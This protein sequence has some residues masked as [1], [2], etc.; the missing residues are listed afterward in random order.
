[1]RLAAALALLVLFSSGARA[2]T[3]NLEAAKSH[4]AAAKAYYDEARYDEALREFREAYRLSKKPALL[5]NIALCDEKQKRYEAAAAS[6][7]LYL[8]LDPKAEDRV[9]IERKIADLDVLVQ[10]PPSPPPEAAQISVVPA[11]PARTERARPA[12]RETGSR[13]RVA[14]W[15]VGGL[16]LALGAA[17][18]G[19]G[20]AA[21][22]DYQ[23]LV[24]TCG[25]S[26]NQCP[27]G[28]DRIRD[29]GQRL[30][31]STAVLGSLG[32]IS[33]VAAIALYF[34]EGRGP[35]Q[36]TAV[37]PLVLRDGAGL[38]AALSF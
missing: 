4:F 8:K 1:M 23:S 12:S 10:Q 19:T 22:A 3:F 31:V 26:H 32:G 9:G 25:F 35:A 29:E 37:A 15:V 21:H 14:T 7:R 17:A 30:Q 27:P 11:I 2:E 33:V 38:A 5:F 28:F 18:L 20:L 34:V 24:D 13:R 16:G 36:R 6:L